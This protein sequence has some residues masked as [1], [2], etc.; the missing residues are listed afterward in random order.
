MATFIF[1]S[2]VF[3]LACALLVDRIGGQPTRPGG[4][5]AFNRT[6]GSLFVGFGLLLAA[7]KSR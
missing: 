2:F 3:P 1:F 7:A 5:K 4:I 6:N